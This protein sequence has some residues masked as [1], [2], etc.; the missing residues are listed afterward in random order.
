M[1]DGHAF[2][3]DDL[4]RLNQLAGDLTA[5]IIEAW[6]AQAICDSMNEML[7]RNPSNA[8]AGALVERWTT[9]SG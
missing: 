9:G 5:D 1:L 8:I 2:A 7:T 4:L 6:E 3:A